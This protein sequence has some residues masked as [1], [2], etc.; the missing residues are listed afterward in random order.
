MNQR[1][2]RLKRKVGVAGLSA[3]TAV[4][5]VVAFG[6]GT[7]FAAT[8]GTLTAQ[9]QPTVVA[10][11]TNQ[12][13]GNWIIP[14]F[15]TSTIGDKVII[16]VDDSDGG[17]CLTNNDTVGFSSTPTVTVTPTIAGETPP[18]MTAAIQSSTA[19]S[20]AG[21]AVGTACS[22]SGVKNELV[23]TTTALGTPAGSTWKVTISGIAYDL[24]KAVATGPVTVAAAGVT[25]NAGSSNAVIS[26]IVPA[27]NVPPTGIAPATLN[28]PISD[29][30]L[31]ET[32]A[33]AIPTGAW[34]CVTLTGPGAPGGSTGP[35]FSGTSTPT[36]TSGGNGATVN[37]GNGGPTGT[38][39][40]TTFAPAG[41]GPFTSVFFKVST[42]SGPTT[43]S[44]FTLTGLKLDTRT[45]AGPVTAVVGYAT[46]SAADACNQAS[47]NFVPIATK[48]LLSSI[49]AL[50]RI[51]GADRYGTAA[52]IFNPQFCRV[53]V[54]LTRGDLFP[55]ALTGTYE[56]GARATGILLTQPNAIPSI[57]LSALR[58]AGITDVFIIGG[59]AAVSDAVATQLQQTASYTCGGG[60]QRLDANGNPQFLKVTRI[61][62]ADR[63]ET[64]QLVAQ[65]P[66]PAIM[67]TADLD[68][69]ATPN[70]VRTAVVA[71]G[72]N[73]PDALAGGPMAVAGSNAP[74]YAIA[75][76]FAGNDNALATSVTCP[77]FC[78]GTTT[79]GT[80][81][82]S[83]SNGFPLVLT[84]PDA[85]SGPAHDAL[86][87][88]QIKSVIL[89][90]GTAA[91]SDAVAS[92]I[93]GLGITVM[94][95]GGADRMDT[96][97]LV[98]AFETS[99][100]SDLPAAPTTACAATAGTSCTLPVG[101]FYRTDHANLARGDDFADALAGG[102]HAGFLDDAFPTVCASSTGGGCFAGP[103][104]I[105]L[106]QDPD[107]LSTPTHD[108]LA[109]NAAANV[110]NDAAG[111]TPNGGIVT[112]DIFGGP[113][114][115]TPATMTAAQNALTGA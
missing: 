86:L 66:N 55:D 93:T 56:A 23:L 65:D 108:Y 47:P 1:T 14:D 46:T 3:I 72:A 88:L 10:S 19:T 85:L 15:T 109:A 18:T 71:S 40:G 44:S 48:L 22:T 38:T 94:R 97:R 32:Q 41:T 70:P 77:I 2:S 61:G 73:F 36:V 64:G 60:T 17:N 50:N 53:N 100:F 74:A 90:G 113:A 96:A 104:P 54:V 13:A 11:Q 81:I 87:N 12:P 83:G 99:T 76:F 98:A 5:S 27:A 101:L 29:V 21:P 114:A 58:Q 7:A 33:G 28:Q 24:G 67:G 84:T 49:V 82:N 105:L 31:T 20:P 69:D 37:N 89:L 35:S 68:G 63:Y 102:P 51:G 45:A 106:T 79:W 57:T 78:T 39:S 34:V 103:T 25:A 6:S 26:N 4:A 42:A 52:A 91:V 16:D 112:M 43:P 95:I 30:S 75:T 8:S 59:P 62:G 115:I 9:S 110:V 80:G 92:S 107:T 111:P